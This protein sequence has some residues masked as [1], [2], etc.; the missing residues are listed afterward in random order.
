MPAEV[1][2]MPQLIKKLE[3]KYGRQTMQR[4]SDEALK[5]GAKVFVDELKRQLA[6]F[7]DTGAEYDEVVM[8]EPAYDATG[9][10]YVKVH[11]DGPKDRWRVIHLNENGTVQ[12]KNPRG[13]GKIAAALI[14]SEKA[15]HNAIRDVLKRRM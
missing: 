12:H 13:K 6:T 2:G 3:K 14:H 4:L 7:K 1:K 5:E 9:T 11:W 8:D 15:Y 10:R